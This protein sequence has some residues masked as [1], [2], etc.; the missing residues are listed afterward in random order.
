M[1]IQPTG[2]GPGMRR[3][4]GAISTTGSWTGNEVLEQSLLQ[5]PGQVMGEGGVLEQSLLQ[6]PGQV[7]GEEVLEQSLPQDPEQAMMVKFK[8]ICKTIKKF[9]PLLSSFTEREEP[10]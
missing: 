5:D 4:S 3:S 6:D 2:S 10:G 8:F 7:M 1:R 9:S